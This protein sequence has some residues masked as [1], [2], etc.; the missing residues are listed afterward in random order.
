M[1]F[2]CRAYKAWHRQVIDGRRRFRHQGL[3]TG[4]AQVPCR[5]VHQ[6]TMRIQNILQIWGKC[7]WRAARRMQIARLV[8]LSA[9]ILSFAV[10]VFLYRKQGLHTL[11]KV[12]I[13]QSTERKINTTAVKVSTNAWAQNNSSKTTVASL[14]TQ[15]F[16]E[17]ATTSSGITLTGTTKKP[18]VCQEYNLTFVSAFFDFGDH[19]KGG[20]W[21][22][23]ADVLPVERSL[24][25]HFRSFDLLH[26]LGQVWRAHPATARTHGATSHPRHIR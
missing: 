17:R 11:N 10:Y 20:S 22:Y 23:C 15:T 12:L 8:I 26:G 3:A 2:S 25:S 19:P 4:G 16:G 5:G 21:R 18:V 9:T 24:W 14:S 1:T 6:L 13:A 7:R